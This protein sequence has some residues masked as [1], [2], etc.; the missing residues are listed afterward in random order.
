M[1]E[2]IMEDPIVS[3]MEV[4]RPNMLVVTGPQGS[5][6]HLFA[7]LFNLHPEVYGWNMD[8]YWVGHH[9]EPF[10]EY[11]WDPTTVDEFGWDL[12]SDYYITS[13][14]CP[15]YRNKEPQ[16]PKYEEFITTVEE[17]CDI[18]V[19]IIGRDRT[20]L[21][22]EQTRVR[23]GHTTPLALKE[24]EYL[25]TL[26][27]Y[28]ISMELVFLYR[29]N[30]LKQVGRDLGFPV[31]ENSDMINDVLVDESN[32]KYIQEVG[33]QPLDLEIYKACDES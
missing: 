22:Y 5:G 27:P 8:K 33:E 3:E 28:F 13:I 21:E 24:F 6:N 12:Y 2:R 23:K 1:G 15:Y 10:S 26:D 11:W 32:K 4:E 20:I 17:H 25:Y 7:K 30:Y 9:T 29:E 18:L 31:V 16:I 19:A 14:S